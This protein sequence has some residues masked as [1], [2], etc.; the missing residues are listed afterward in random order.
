[1]REGAS[2][3]DLDGS[4]VA[5][6]AGDAAR[7]P[8]GRS[9]PGLEPGLEARAREGD[10]LERAVA[11]ADAASSEGDVASARAALDEALAID[12]HF[13]D[14]LERLAHLARV[15]G[16]HEAHAAALER[17]LEAVFDGQRAPDYLRELGE[18]LSEHLDERE[19]GLDA[20]HRYLHWRPL[21]DAIFPRI[22]AWLVAA[23]RLGELAELWERRAE[24][25]EDGADLAKGA[26]MAASS[27][28][29]AARCYLACDRPEIAAVVVRRALALDR[30]QPELIELG[31]RALAADGRA[32]EA[33]ELLDE[34]LP[35]LLDGPLKDELLALGGR[36]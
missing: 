19:R 15:E 6:H 22:R 8:G 12:P 36:T 14:A 7:D 17:L 9:S 35:M 31:V 28:G 5:F 3:G 29:E 1:V 24:A 27:L 2:P 33:R 4:A 11:R 16:D 25:W 13:V 32:E 20:W 30:G 18:V 23:G 21:D 34:L 26:R 10:A